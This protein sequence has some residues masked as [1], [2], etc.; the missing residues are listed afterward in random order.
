M[1]GMS[2]D[3]ESYIARGSFHHKLR[4]KDEAAGSAQRNKTNEG[5]KIDVQTLRR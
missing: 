5:T 3:Y 4:I 2:N 1:L